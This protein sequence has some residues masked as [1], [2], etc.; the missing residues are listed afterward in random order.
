[1]DCSTALMFLHSMNWIHS[2]FNY[3][4]HNPS[5]I[6]SIFINISLI[7]QK[8]FIFIIKVFYRDILQ[9]SVHSVADRPFCSPIV[10]HSYKSWRH[11]PAD[12]RVTT[13]WSREFM[14]QRHQENSERFLQKWAEKTKATQT[15]RAE[16][17][18]LNYDGNSWKFSIV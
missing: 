3:P 13:K 15:S 17:T 1:M 16:V 18:N 14:N 11:Q 4:L 6:S 12:I 10:F 7:F 2:Y 5:S 8:H 9:L